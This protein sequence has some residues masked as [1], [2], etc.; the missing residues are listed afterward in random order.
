VGVVRLFQG[1]TQKPD[2]PS[3]LVKNHSILMKFGTQV[4]IYVY[5]SSV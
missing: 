5:Y 1:K 2:I 3:I 4:E